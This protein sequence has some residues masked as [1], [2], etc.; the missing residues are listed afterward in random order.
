V[1]T[2]FRLWDTYIPRTRP[3]SFTNVLQRCSNFSDICALF[4]YQAEEHIVQTKD[5]YLLCLHRICR[6]SEETYD[7][8]LGSIRGK[9]KPVVY[10]HHGLLMDSEVWVCQID[11]KLSLPFRLVEEGYDVWFGNNRGNKYSRKSLHHNASET[12]FWDF[13]MVLSL[14]FFIDFRTSLHCMI[15]LIR[16]IMFYILPGPRV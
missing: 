1:Y 6:K 15:S 3:K 8:N 14:I 4:G 11:E 16:S 7:R 2:D 13:S 9:R 5:G 12:A 10:L